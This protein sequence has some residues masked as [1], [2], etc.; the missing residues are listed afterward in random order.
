VNSNSF[1]CPGSC[2]GLVPYVAGFAELDFLKSVALSLIGTFWR[3]PNRYF[4][5]IKVNDLLKHLCCIRTGTVIW[6][7]DFYVFSKNVGISYLD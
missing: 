2:F 1:F 6:K 5:L 4:A 7:T 3:F